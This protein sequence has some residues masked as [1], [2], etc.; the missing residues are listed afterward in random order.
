[1]GR[2]ERLHLAEKPDLLL[3]HDYFSFTGWALSL[4]PSTSP[5]EIIRS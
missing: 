5:R 2:F 3:A 1:M 4:K